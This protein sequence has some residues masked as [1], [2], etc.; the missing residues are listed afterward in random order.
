[1]TGENNTYTW[2]LSHCCNQRFLGST[3]RSPAVAQ[4][5]MSSHFSITP[6]PLLGPQS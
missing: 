6:S 5:T 1:M 4:E 2:T 3:G